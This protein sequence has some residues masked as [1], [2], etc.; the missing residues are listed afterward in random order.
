[1]RAVK[2]KAARPNPP[3]KTKAK[4]RAKAAPRA[5]VKP[6]A[7]AFDLAD[8]LAQAGWKEAD[9]ALARA[10]RDFTSLEAASLALGRKLRGGALS[11]Q[12]LKVESA[13]LAASQAMRQA[14]RKRNL[15][16]FGE[17]GAVT[18]FDERLHAL[19]EP[20][21]R[22]PARV[23]VFAQGVMRGVGPEAEIILKALVAP[24]RTRPNRKM[25]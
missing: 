22:P 20:A 9:A 24:S 18:A 6:A 14:A 8:M 12:A 17:T 1:M 10:L 13:L 25:R 3:R 5:A 15:N 2:K 7:P 19:A 16:R 21:K 23:K 4:A 11:A